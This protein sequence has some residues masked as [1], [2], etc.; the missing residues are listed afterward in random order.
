[1]VFRQNIQFGFSVKDCGKA[2]SSISKF[3]LCEKEKKISLLG[4][5][6]WV[7]VLAILKFHPL[8]ILKS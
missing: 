7:Y 1:V 6:A 2:K 8:K 3:R 4:R 5:V